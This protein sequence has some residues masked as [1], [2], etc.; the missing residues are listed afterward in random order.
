MRMLIHLGAYVLLPFLAFVLQ[1]VSAAAA[2]QGSAAANA[3]QGA[4]RDGQH[5]FDF[6]VG[7]WKTHLKL[8][9]H[10]LSG[11]TTWV[12]CDGTTVVRKV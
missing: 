1:S 7:T 12:E 10:P 8:L 5:D 3:T 6:E 11:S 2:E 4:V 9:V